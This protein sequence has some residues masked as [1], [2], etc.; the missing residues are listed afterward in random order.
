[1]GERLHSLKNALDQ[2]V[3]FNFPL[4]SDEFPKGSLKYNNYVDC[5]KKVSEQKLEQFT[6]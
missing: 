3:V 4:K 2:L 1:M 6:T 5:I